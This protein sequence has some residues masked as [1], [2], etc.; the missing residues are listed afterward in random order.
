MSLLLLLLLRF[1]GGGSCGCYIVGVTG[2]VV[3]VGLV[4]YLR[5]GWDVAA[6]SACWEFVV[7]GV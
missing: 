7:I 3:I 6:G 5:L 2:E 1:A 4:D